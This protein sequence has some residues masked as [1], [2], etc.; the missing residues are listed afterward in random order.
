MCHL[1]CYINV[2]VLSVL[3][4]IPVEPALYW[5]LSFPVELVLFWSSYLSRLQTKQ[6]LCYW[7]VSLSGLELY[8]SC[9]WWAR[10]LNTH[11]CLFLTHHFVCISS[12]TCKLWHAC[13]C[14]THQTT[15][16]LSRMFCF[17]LKVAKQFQATR[18]SLV[19][20]L[21]SCYLC[22]VRVDN[23]TLGAYNFS[24]QQTTILLQEFI[25]VC[26]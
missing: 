19:Q 16:L 6:K 3:L 10:D 15:H 20:T 14:A 22:I 17:V 24:T 26:A 4:S 11:H 18:E 23:K 5:R 13:N 1:L 21:P 2:W 25:F 7:K 8:A 9:N 12:I